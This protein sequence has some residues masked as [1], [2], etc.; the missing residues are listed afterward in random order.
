MAK[1]SQA[2]KPSARKRKKPAA[3]PPAA[4]GQR[5]LT[6]PNELIV[7]MYRQ[8][9]GD[10]FLLALPGRNGATKYVL[11]DCGVHAR[12]TDGPARLA[13]VLDHLIAATGPH[14]DVVV[15]THEHADHLS[16]FVQ[17]NSPFLRDDVT[18]GE[19]WLAWTERRGDHQ[20]DALRRKR[21]TAQQLIDKA[22]DEAQRRA[23]PDG[24]ALASQLNA[25]TDFDRPPDGSVDEADVMRRIAALK[26]RAALVAA[27]DALPSLN[28]D[29]PAGLAA[30]KKAKKAPSSNE[31]ALGLLAVKATDNKITYC[32]P[33]TV[34]D[35]DGVSNFRA[36]VLGPPRSELLEKPNPTKIRGA[37]ENTPGGMYKEVYL[38]SSSA[39]R[40]LELSPRLKLEA[41]AVGGALP[42]DWRY[43]FAESYRRPCELAAR[44]GIGKGRC[45]SNDGPPPEST[46]TFIEGTYLDPSAAWRRVDGDWLTAA[47]TVALNLAE[48]TNNTSLV[49]AFECGVAGKGP[50]LLFAAD[51]QV[52]NWLSWRDQPYGDKRIKA[53]DLVSRTI[54]YKVGHHG[55]HNGTVRRDPRDN[56][57]SDPIGAPFGLELM[58]DLIAMI[59][60]DFDAAR[61][62]MPDPWRMPHEPL[63]RRLREKARRRV[64]RSDL[65]ITPLDPDREDADVVPTTTA[66]Q[67]VPGVKGVRWRRS[68]ETFKTG[69]QGP[70]CY[71]VVFPAGD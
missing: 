29:A 68:A 12:E 30:A 31:L 70:L 38:A 28:D 59:P 37:T 9:L 25:L 69:T 54:L 66:W 50:V 36:Y 19:L 71:D 41:T 40:A 14:I 27:I 53:D 34:R 58:D 56:S 43:P 32:V 55:S 6:Q 15:A 8:G 10:C 46:K 48:D 45:W 44:S 39:N 47:E 21:G 51:A 16:G 11:I 67:P 63:Y 5:L 42:E 17:K 7:R 2:R 35:V 60:V 1:T 26:G 18:I 33:G 64:L 20:A 49:L 57:G 61:K 65:E 24:P 13:Q 22:V 4:A 23:G 52:G 3:K 62:E